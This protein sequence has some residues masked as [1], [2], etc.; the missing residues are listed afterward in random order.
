MR[1]SLIVTALVVCIAAA[2]TTNVCFQKADGQWNQISTTRESAQDHLYI[3]P[4]SCWSLCPCPPASKRVDVA[5]NIGSENT[6]EIWVLPNSTTINSLTV[7]ISHAGQRAIVPVP[8]YRLQVDR[9]QP[10]HIDVDVDDEY[11][12]MFSQSRH[13]A[14]LPEEGCTGCGCGDTDGVYGAACPNGRMV[15]EEG[16]A[17]CEAGCVG[18]PMLGKTCRRTVGECTNVGTYACTDGRVVCSVL[19]PELKTCESLR[20]KCGNYVGPCG[21]MLSCGAC[22]EGHHCVDGKCYDLQ[23]NE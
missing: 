20:Y 6:V 21:E 16:E 2:Q 10:V 23:I 22:D 3:Y 9:T 19:A 8:S 5:Y 18:D 13:Y 17:W 15:C 14:H 7:T 11:F 4:K 1:F 12:G